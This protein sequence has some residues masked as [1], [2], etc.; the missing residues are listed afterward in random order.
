MK[1]PPGNYF[2]DRIQA[3]VADDSVMILTGTSILPTLASLQARSV[4][5]RPGI[6]PEELLQIKNTC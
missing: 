6:S 4:C 2:S 1:Q 5:S 3:A